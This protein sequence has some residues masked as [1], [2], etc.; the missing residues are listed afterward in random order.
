M[1]YRTFHWT[2]QRIDLSS[3]V[4]PFVL[5]KGGI[6]NTTK[7]EVVCS[8]GNSVGDFSTHISAKVVSFI[9]TAVLCVVFGPGIVV[10]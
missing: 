3:I 2:D 10:K 7:N 1:G 9:M 8:V 4:I 6:M 5:N